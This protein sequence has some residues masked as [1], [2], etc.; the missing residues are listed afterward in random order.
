MPFSNR[1]LL[2]SVSILKWQLGDLPECGGMRVGWGPAGVEEAPLEGG[3]LRRWGGLCGS[4]PGFGEWLPA[5]PPFSQADP[6]YE[7]STGSREG[8]WDKEQQEGDHSLRENSKVK[9]NH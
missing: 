7:G 6:A 8:A 9:I 5:D 4:R 3:G 1:Q 2:S